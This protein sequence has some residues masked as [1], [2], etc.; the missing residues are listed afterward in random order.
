MIA[1]QGGDPDAALPVARESARRRGAGVRR[2]DPARRDGRRSGRLAARRRPGPQGGPGAG[3]CRR[4]AG[5]PAPAT[6]YARA[7][8]CSPC[9]PTTPDRVRARAGGAR[10]WVR[11]SGDSSTP[12]P[13]PPGRSCTRR[14]IARLRRRRPAAAAAGRRSRRRRRA[15]PGPRSRWRSAGQLLAGR[16]VGDLAD[17]RRGADAGADAHRVG[18]ADLVDAVVELGA[19]RLEREDL[20]AEAGHQRQRQVAVGDRAAERARSARSTSTW[21]H[22][23]SPVASANRS[24][25]SWSIS[26]QSLVPSSSPAAAASSS[27]W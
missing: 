26:S 27:R 11:L 12:A 22:W 4:R 5:T 7:S 21:I 2:A 6:R 8:R 10:G 23:W 20:A 1:A 13:T 24:T 18:E 17:R 19:G 9:S 25:R 14:A 3:R 16:Q 15:C